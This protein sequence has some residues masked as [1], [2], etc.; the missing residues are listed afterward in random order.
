MEAVLKTEQ[1]LIEHN[2]ELGI[3]SKLGLLGLW[4]RKLDVKY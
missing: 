4:K 1:K 3:H 2:V